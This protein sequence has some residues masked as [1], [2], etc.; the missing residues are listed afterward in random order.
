MKWSDGLGQRG[1]DG[2]RQMMSTPLG[3]VSACRVLIALL[4][5]LT[6]VANSVVT[7]QRVVALEMEVAVSRGSTTRKKKLP[8]Q[9]SNLN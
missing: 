7:L 8:G 4:E 1:V 3:P 6:T 2:R 5:M 9:D